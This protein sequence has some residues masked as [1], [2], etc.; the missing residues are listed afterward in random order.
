MLLIELLE[1]RTLLN[2]D[3]FLVNDF[4]V[5]PQQT[6]PGASAV[7]MSQ[8]GG[9]IV[10]YTGQ[11]ADDSN[12]AFVRRFN[13]S[14]QPLSTDLRINGTTNGNQDEASVAVSPSGE[15]VTV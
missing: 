14:D 6:T 15:F 7:A 10:A 2:G 12:G 8:G 4:K 1:N 9:F 11:G 5:G 13:G 3:E